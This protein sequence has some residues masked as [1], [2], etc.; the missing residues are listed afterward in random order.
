[1]RSS[2]RSTIPMCRR[3]RRGSARRARLRRWSC[4]GRIS[5]A[6]WSRS[7]MRRPRCSI[8]SICSMPGAPRPAAVIGTAVGFVGAAESKEALA[9]DGRVPYLIVKGRKGGSAMAVAAVNAHCERC[10]M[11][12]LDDIAGGAR[13]GTLYGIGVGPGDVRYLTLRAAGLVRSVDVVAYFAKRGL[14]GNARRIVTPLMAAGRHELRLEYPVTE[15]V[16]VADASYQTQIADFYR[17]AADSIA[18]HL[19]RWAF[20]RTARRGRSVLLWLLHAYVAAARARSSGRGRAGCHR[21]VRLLDQRQCADHLGRRYPVGAAG[22]AAEDILTDRLDALRGGRDHEGRAQS[23]EG[24]AR[25]RQRGPACR[26]RSMSSAAPWKTSAS[27]R[28]PSASRSGDHI[29]RWC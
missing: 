13:A 3:W 24:E 26:A 29:S 19:A 6:R 4:G 9:A 1:M 20:G 21:H 15:E 2:A 5:P 18:A 25:G 8:C 14:E 7:A 28:W 17:R 23:A 10:R 22:H 16:P 12:M 27:C 11:S